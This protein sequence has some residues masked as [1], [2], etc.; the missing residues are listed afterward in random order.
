MSES[1]K[2][3]LRDMLTLLVVGTLANAIGG[4]A[5]LYAQLF[6]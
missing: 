3:F 6:M 2:Q 5:A 1:D 4:L